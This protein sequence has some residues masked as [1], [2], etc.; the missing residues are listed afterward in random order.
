MKP[1]GKNVQQAIAYKRIEENLGVAFMV[2]SIVQLKHVSCFFSKF[3]L[4]K[5][6]S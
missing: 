3:N 2:E 6:C 4:E 1:I 5:L